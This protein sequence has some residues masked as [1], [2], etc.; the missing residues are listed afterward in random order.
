ML[1]PVPV[2]KLGQFL[3]FFGAQFLAFSILC[4]NYRAIA[5]AGYLGIGL[6]EMLYLG[7]NFSL[8]QYISKAEGWAARLGYMLGGTC[9]SLFSVW[10][11]TTYFGG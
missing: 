9:G 7:L 3:V 1:R 2:S 6:S 8:I 5:K 11:L 10:I 4:W